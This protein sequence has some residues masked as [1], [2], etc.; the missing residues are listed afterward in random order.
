[1]SVP[2][3]ETA[4]WLA[5]R[6]R[7]QAL[8][9]SIVPQSAIAWPKRPFTK[10]TLNGQPA[11][12]IEVRHLPNQVGRLMV[13]G[14]GPHQRP[15]ILQLDYMSPT[16]GAL[17]DVQVTEMAGRIAS[18]FP[19]DMVLSAAGVRV[20]VERAPDVAQGF[21]D[22]PYWRVPVSIRWECLA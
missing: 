5:L 1:M 10:P 6:G 8:P 7:V 2:A 22:G 4:I 14:S 18:H 3:I 13:K 9:V 20:R 17:D 19:A 16:G 15:G 11:P 12:Y 21:A